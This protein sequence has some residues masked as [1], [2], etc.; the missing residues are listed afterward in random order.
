[1]YCFCRKTSYLL[2][3]VRNKNGNTKKSANKEKN[4]KLRKEAEDSMIW[5]N[6]LDFA[7]IDLTDIIDQTEI[8]MIKNGKINEDSDF[9]F[10]EELLEENDGVNDFDFV[11][12][13]GSFVTDFVRP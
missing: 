7:L 1:M 3:D 11:E 13:L 5:K 6:D 4:Q 10:I 9:E 12:D 2:H 8:T